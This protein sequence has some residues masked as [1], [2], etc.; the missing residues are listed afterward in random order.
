MPA[1][2]GTRTEALQ[3][4]SELL[5]EYREDS[6]A[7]AKYHHGLAQ[8]VEQAMFIYILQK[9]PA[10]SKI[11][12]AFMLHIDDASQSSQ[13]HSSQAS[14]LRLL[15]YLVH[16]SACLIPVSFFT[17]SAQGLLTALPLHIKGLEDN[18]HNFSLLSL[19]I[20]LSPVTSYSSFCLSSKL[21]PQGF[22]F[23]LLAST[24]RLCLHKKA[25]L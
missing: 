25:D 19:S 20:H 14:P 16:V 13:N 10:N 18:C 7:M 4:I 12:F 2:L 21:V 9:Q 24:L 3:S 8:K 5:H 15:F 11:V 17:S 6:L 1:E 23:P 22:Y